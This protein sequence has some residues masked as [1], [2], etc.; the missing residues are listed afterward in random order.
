MIPNCLLIY[1]INI[2][3]LEQCLPGS[4]SSDGLEPCETCQRGFYQPQYAQ[5]SCLECPQDTT[6]WQRGSRVQDD[7]GGKFQ[8]YG[9]DPTAWSYK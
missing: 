7:C 2:C 4:T 5:T 1:G 3:P 6:T 9:A 8:L